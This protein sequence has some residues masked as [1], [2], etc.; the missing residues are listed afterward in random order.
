LEAALKR[1]LSA[2][3]PV[4]ILHHLRDFYILP[5]L[6]SIIFIDYFL[7]MSFDPEPTLQKL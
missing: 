5:I 6:Q 7:R 2:E 1:T 3:Y 4:P